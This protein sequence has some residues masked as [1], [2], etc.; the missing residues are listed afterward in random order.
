MSILE[1]IREFLFS[2]PLLGDGVINIDYLGD[3]PKEYTVDGVPTNSVIKRYADGGKL[4]QYTFIFASREWHGENVAVNSA[5]IK[6][7]EDFAQ[8]IESE[9]NQGNLPI[10]S[11]NKTSQEISVLATDIYLTGRVEMQDIKYN[12][13]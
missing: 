4:K 7:Y 3:V 13:D 5:N 2:C 10:L 11:E 8:W 12:A 9:S 6:F 1:S